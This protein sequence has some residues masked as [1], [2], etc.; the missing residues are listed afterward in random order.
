MGSIYPVQDLQMCFNPAQSWQLGWYQE[1]RLEIDFATAPPETRVEL[2]GVS[3]Y[4]KAVHGREYA[5]VKVNNPAGGPDVYIGFNRAGGINADTMEARDQVTVHTKGRASSAHSY[6]VYKGTS[7]VYS[8]KNFGNTG[9]RLDV[10][11]MDID[12]SFAVLK[13]NVWVNVEF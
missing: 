1:S 11:V 7:G 10:R 4:K 8:I 6:L 3:D 9:K 13:A 5:A 12:Y 2:V